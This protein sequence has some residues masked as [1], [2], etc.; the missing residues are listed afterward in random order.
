MNGKKI[1]K[2]LE[3][4]HLA[5]AEF[6]GSFADLHQFPDEYSDVCFIGRSNSGKS[7]L[8][9]ALIKNASLVKISKTPG[10]TKTVN[11]FKRKN[12][13]LVDLPGYGYAR[14]NH[15]QRDT[16]SLIIG[17]YLNKRKNIK[18]A[19]LLLDC[20]RDLKETE[21]YIIQL[22]RERNIPLILLL[23][24]IDRLNQ[25]EKAKL[26][27]KIHKEYERLFFLVFPISG[28]EREN[29]DQ[30]VHYINSLSG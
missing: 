28:R 5:E 13:Y 25:K 6:L 22:M 8:L 23:T 1:A 30:L 18:T 19:F 20:Y 11:F 27:V 7:T 17:N 29:T 9:S 16:L 3:R 21:H 10:S 15:A 2:T 26:N 12:L 14:A 24:K 4:E